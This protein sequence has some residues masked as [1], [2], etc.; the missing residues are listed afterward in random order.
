M[1]TKLRRGK[2]F[3]GLSQYHELAERAEHDCNPDH[4]WSG[5][6]RSRDVQSWPGRLAT[7]ANK[8]SAIVDDPAAT[9]LADRLLTVANAIDQRRHTFSALKTQCSRMVRDCADAHMQ[10]LLSVPKQLLCRILH[11]VAMSFI[12]KPDAA[13]GA[14]LMDLLPCAVATD[15]PPRNITLGLLLQRRESETQSTAQLADMASELQK[16]KLGPGFC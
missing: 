5:K 12:K 1:F 7:A 10:V 13:S 16:K 4:L 15:A 3:K 8:L 11:S 14:L 2:S 6:T 9:T